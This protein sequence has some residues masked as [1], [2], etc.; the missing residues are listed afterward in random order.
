M[1]GENNEYGIIAEMSEES[2]YKNIRELVVNSE[3]LE[4]YK[5]QSRIRGGFFSKENTV[6]D[7]ENY[8]DN[9]VAVDKY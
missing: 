7:V 1:L 4:Y 9:L 3:M 8:M 2:L 6:M 5:K